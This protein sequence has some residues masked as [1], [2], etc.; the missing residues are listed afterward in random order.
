MG[1]V[2]AVQRLAGHRDSFGFFSEGEGPGQGTS[3]ETRL[4][5]ERGARSH[6]RPVRKLM[7]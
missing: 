5:M 1:G 6:A 3:F 4:R 2:T 7:K